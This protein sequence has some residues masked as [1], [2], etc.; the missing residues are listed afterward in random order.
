MKVI[1]VDDSLV[2]RKIIAGVVKELGHEP[3]HAAN[4]QHLLDILEERAEEIGLILL[5]WNMPGLDGM[6]ILKRMRERSG[7]NTIPVFMV[8]T[9][10]ED[11]KMEE[12]INTGAKDYL[13]KPFT[14]KE[15]AA[16][17]EKALGK[18]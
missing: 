9:E 15:L 16:K 4:G 2:M 14:T 5:D 18:A 1:V 6:E 11:A 3:L 13:A 8:S 12:A 7:Y 17:I 10:S